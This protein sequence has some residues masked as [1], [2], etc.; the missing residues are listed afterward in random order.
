MASIW[1]ILEIEKTT[2]ENEIKSAYRRKLVRTNPEDYPEEFKELRSAYEQACE[3]ARRE[4]AAG[5]DTSAGHGNAAGAPDVQGQGGADAQGIGGADAGWGGQASDAQGHGHAGVV[6]SSGH[7]GALGPVELWMAKVKALYGDFYERIRPGRWQALFSEDVCIGLESADEARNALLAFFLEHAKLPQTVWKT[8]D[9]AFS[10]VDDKE[11]LCRSFPKEFIDYVQSLIQY[12]N[13]LDYGLFEGDVSEDFDTYIDD[14]FSLRHAVINEKPEEG[15]R[16]FKRLSSGP[17]YHPFTE[18]E[19]ARLALLEGDRA[20]AMAVL[21]RLYERYG[22]CPYIANTYCQLLL[23]AGEFEAAKPVC[24]AVLEQNPASYEAGLHYVRCL[25][26]EGAYANAKDKLLELFELN[27][28]DEDAMELLK[29]LNSHLMDTYR[30]RL[31]ACP[32][33]LDALLE[34]GWCLCQNE[35]YRECLALLL[36]VTPDAD[37][38]YDYINLRGRIYLCLEQYED[39][40]PWL[41]RWRE[42]IEGLVDD[43]S[44][45]YKK[46]RGRLGYAYYAVA[47]CYSWM[48]EHGM[49]DGFDRALENIEKA[50]EAPG[51][52]LARPSC[53]Y[54]KA[55]ILHKMGRN[56]ECLDVCS[57]LLAEEAGYYSAYVLRQE[58]WLAL[59][60]AQEVVNDFYRAIRIYPYYSRPYELA[61]RVFLDFGQEKEALEII[62]AAEAASVMSDELRLIKLRCLRNQAQSPEDY[63]KALAYFKEAMQASESKRTDAWLSSMYRVKALCLMEC[64]RLTEASEAIQTAIEKKASDDWNFAVKAQILESQGQESHALQIYLELSARLPDHPFLTE[65]IGKLYAAR[66]ETKKA[67][68]Y[69]E[70]TLALN[71]DYPGCDLTLGQLYEQMAREKKDRYYCKKALDYFEKAA[72]AVRGV[73]SDKGGQAG[74]DGQSGRDGQE[75]PGGRECQSTPEQQHILAKIYGGRAEIYEMLEDFEAAAGNL[76]KALELDPKNP[77]LLLTKGRLLARLRSY[78]EAVKVFMDGLFMKSGYESE[79]AD[80]ICMIYILSGQKENAKMWWKRLLAEQGTQNQFMGAMRAGQ[81]YLYIEEKPSKAV[82]YF[83][84]AI[85]SMSGRQDS[86]DFYHGKYFLGCALYLSRRRQKAALCFDELVTVL[87]REHPEYMNPRNVREIPPDILRILLCTRIWLAA[88]GRNGLVPD[89]GAGSRVSNALE[90]FLKG[91]MALAARMFAEATDRNGGCDVECEGMLRLINK[92]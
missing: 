2:D 80:Q 56:E 83:N 35:D 84:R 82:K 24:E 50:I 75:G 22:P 77:A 40:L 71:E 13:F 9:Q 55:E 62:E 23:E 65:R 67:I 69:L 30:Q 29:R 79:F 12:E 47:S 63:E 85:V 52:G 72:Q 28:G 3:Q 11:E 66:G 45:E 88:C 39:A 48:G 15:Q 31:A 51:P 34:L 44:K 5:A 33:D 36:P 60:R 10:I 68:H 18:V 86:N 4:K 73:Q 78:E 42:A 87:R 49:R 58:A 7:D 76:E 37:H 61:A 19:G 6:S 89:S 32:E 14:Y 81:Y 70:K 16:I 8:V 17:I 1:D 46:R 20:G 64:Q 92:R 38:E 91:D 43:G 54:M 53:L 74:R 21:R 26:N 90:A 27:S 25:E 41:L 59:G 57:G